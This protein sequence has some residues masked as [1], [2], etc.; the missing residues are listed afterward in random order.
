MRIRLDISYKGTNYFGW[1]VQPDR[2]TVQQ[3]IE[4]AL[5]NLFQEP[6]K[7]QGSGRTD[8]GVHAY[9][10]V[11][12]FKIEKDLSKFDVIRGLNRY[13]PRDIR[14]KNAFSVPDEFNSLRSSISKTYLYKI[15]NGSTANP[16]TNDLALWVPKTINLEYLNQIT[17]PLIGVHDFAA[18][19]TTGTELATSVREVYDARW[20]LQDNDEIWFKISGNGFLKQ[21][22]RNI[23]GTLLDGHW[24][25][26]HSPKSIA[27][28]LDSKDRAKAGSTAPAQ[29][30]YLFE[31]IYPQELDKKCLKT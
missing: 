10:Q 26:Q 19:Q 14:V 25:S 23:V 18:F 17:Q 8:A 20:T 4:T 3:E 12:D 30:L 29:G 31:V 24:K 2:N 7:T 28:I 1:Q 15:T 21:M 5:K 9:Q 11:V 13:L 22:V 16:L 6:I 27:K